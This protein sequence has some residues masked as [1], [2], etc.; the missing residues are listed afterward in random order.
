MNKARAYPWVGAVIGA[1]IGIVVVSMLGN[2][3]GFLFNE[4][5]LNLVIIGASIGAGIGAIVEIRGRGDMFTNR[6][7]SI[8]GYTIYG[9]ATVIVN[10]TYSAIFLAT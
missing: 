6:I 4:T 1:A 2:R 5:L 9:A 8:I 3:E 10:A 7:N